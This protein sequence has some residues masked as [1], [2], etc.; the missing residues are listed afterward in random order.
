LNDFICPPI[1]CKECKE[2]C[3]KI[4]V[5]VPQAF[6]RI[7]G[8]LFTNRIGKIVIALDSSFDFYNENFAVL[9]AGIAQVFLEGFNETD[10]FM[11][12]FKELLEGTK[13]LNC[14][15]KF[16]ELRT[17]DNL[18]IFVARIIK[19]GKLH[20]LLSLLLTTKNF[21]RVENYSS[22]SP[23]QS[24]EFIE[25]LRAVTAPLQNCRI[26]GK[27]DIDGFVKYKWEATKCIS[28]S[29]SIRHSV[30]RLIES[31]FERKGEEIKEATE[32]LINEIII[33]FKNGFVRPSFSP[34]ES[35]RHP[36]YCFVAGS[37][38]DVDEL[39]QIEKMRD[40]I[41]TLT[42]LLNDPEE[43]LHSLL[44]EGLRAGMLGEWVMLACAAGNNEG[45]FKKSSP[46]ADHEEM[47]SFTNALFPLNY[48]Y[49]FFN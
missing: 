39:K 12:K 4:Q 43:M 5:S 8:Y 45:L 28:P 18:M 31:V 47:L 38:F 15:S 20:E 35:M 10:S 26:V 22:T 1:C 40:V 42:A 36:W 11:D 17:R 2:F 24:P 34:V 13:L 21:W 6:E 33:F 19:I 7:N 41:E 30:K 3:D 27:L 49:Y 32:E 48:I 23:M 37:A 25:L 46:I 9:C 14:L 44:Y 29:A 16:P